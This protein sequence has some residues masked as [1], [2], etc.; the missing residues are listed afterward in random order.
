MRF[1]ALWPLLTVRGNVGYALRRRK[2]A[3]PESARRCAEVLDRVGLGAL[4]GRYPHELSGC[5]QQRVALA[6]A[7]V[8][9]PGL[10]LF[11][12]PLSSLDADL[13]ERLRVEIATMTRETGATAVYVTHD[14]SEAAPSPTWPTAAAG[15]TTS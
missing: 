4:A 15:T 1:S 11:D 9:R 2:L 3:G 6:R 14:Q 10:L 12:E 5:E 8:A 13:R 7:V